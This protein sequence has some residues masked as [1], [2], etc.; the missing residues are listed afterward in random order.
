MVFACKN[1]PSNTFRFN[2]GGGPGSGG[3]SLYRRQQL[4]CR[5][6]GKVMRVAGSL[7]CGH[8]FDS[9]FQEP[10][11]ASKDP[12]QRRPSHFRRL[13]IGDVNICLGA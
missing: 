10:P 1:V 9:I 13:F 6:V 11:L 3:F 7:E 12:H 4:A 8:L 5:K 2:H